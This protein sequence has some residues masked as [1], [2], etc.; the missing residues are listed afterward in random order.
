MQMTCQVRQVSDKVE[1][2]LQ[3]RQTTTGIC[4]TWSVTDIEQLPIWILAQI[5]ELG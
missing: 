3:V 1:T 2:R 4:Q 5:E